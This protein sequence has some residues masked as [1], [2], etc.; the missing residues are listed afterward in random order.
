MKTLEL[1]ETEVTVLKNTMSQMA[2]MVH[3]CPECLDGDAEGE[4]LEKIE[5]TF[6]DLRGKIDVL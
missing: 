1:T 4:E 5:A 6:T 3:G 2:E